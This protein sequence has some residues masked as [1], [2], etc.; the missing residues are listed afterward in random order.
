MVSRPIQIKYS[1]TNNVVP[2][3]LQGELAFTQT[4]NTFFIG[5]PDGSSDNI[6]IG[7]QMVPGFLT[8]NQA[9]VANSTSGI[10]HV[11][12]DL[13]EISQLISNRITA[14][15]III[16]AISIGNNT[17][18]STINSTSIS[19]GDGIINS[20]FFSGTSNN[21]ASLN[22]YTSDYYINTYGN[23]VING[24]HTYNANIAI[25][26]RIIIG[27]SAG[28]DWDLLTSNGDSGNVFWSN[29]ATVIS[30]TGAGLDG[31]NF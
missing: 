22:G 26:S 23:Y 6:R 27:G 18:N 13:G 9:L 11:I 7:G 15:N 3:L 29:L 16:G 25:N 10:D 24:V 19:I 21:A 30:S 8:A 17:V 28:N 31:G 1:V 4:G 20:S 14:N 5:S 2:T 12:A